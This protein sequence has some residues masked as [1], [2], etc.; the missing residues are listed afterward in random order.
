MFCLCNLKRQQNLPNMKQLH[1]YYNTIQQYWS[2][3]EIFR[4]IRCICSHIIPHKNSTGLMFCNVP[5]AYWGNPSRHFH[6]TKKVPSSCEKKSFPQG[7][8]SLWHQSWYFFLEGVGCVSWIHKSVLLWY[9][10]CIVTSRYGDVLLYWP[11]VSGI[12]RS[13]VD[14]SQKGPVLT[15]YFF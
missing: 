12:H 13:P 14:Y 2:T 1:I 4:N 11:F 10:C 7:C 9:V 5:K 15:S 8:F 6:W 3:L